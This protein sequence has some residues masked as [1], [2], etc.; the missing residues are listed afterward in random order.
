MAASAPAVGGHGVNPARPPF[1]S[2]RLPV[3]LRLW[4]ADGSKALE[5]REKV[6]RGAGEVRGEWR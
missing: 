6:G 5:E 3:S 4:A 2:P 1:P